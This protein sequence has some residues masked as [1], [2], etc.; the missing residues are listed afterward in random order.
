[1]GRDHDQTSFDPGY[2]TLPIDQFVPMVEGIFARKPW[3]PHTQRD[4]PAPH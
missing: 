1:M 2:D 3:G 4:S